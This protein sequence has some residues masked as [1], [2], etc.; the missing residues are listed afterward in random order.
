MDIVVVVV[1]AAFAVVGSVRLLP[2]RPNWI[3]NQKLARLH[4]LS[5]KHLGCLVVSWFVPRKVGFEIHAISSIRWLRHMTTQHR[6][7]LTDYPVFLFAEEQ[8]RGN[9]LVLS[10]ILG[11]FDGTRPN[12]FDRQQRSCLVGAPKSYNPIGLVKICVGVN[13]NKNLA[14]KNQSL[15]FFAFHRRCFDVLRRS[16]SNLSR[17]LRTALCQCCVLLLVT[18]NLL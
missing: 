7:R 12:L 8:E 11:R 9:P 10:S 15:F 6:V 14:L 18:Q 13:E 4:S 16:G 17:L 5:L 1:V 2:G 3:P